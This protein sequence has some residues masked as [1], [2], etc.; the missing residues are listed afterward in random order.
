[1]YRVLFAFPRQE[2]KKHTVPRIVFKRTAGN[3]PKECKTNSTHSAGIHIMRY[4]FE[5]PR[6]AHVGD[7]GLLV[8]YGE[9]IDPEINRK[10]RVMALA[11]NQERPMGL[12]EVIPTYRSLL[13][14]Y[15]P[16]TTD[17]AQLG[18]ALD[19]I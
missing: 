10:V 16:L 9:A 15:D 14:I 13:I 19:H 12:V 2:A 1:M 3:Q 8:E 7:R 5:K 6:L 4:L 17:V 11:L 18:L